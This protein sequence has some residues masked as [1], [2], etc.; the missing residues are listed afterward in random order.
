MDARRRGFGAALLLAVGAL[1]LGRGAAAEL[2]YFQAT[3][4]LDGIGGPAPA[5][6]AT[7]IASVQGGVHLSALDFPAGVLPVSTSVAPT[8]TG[9]P[10]TNLIIGFANG[11]GHFSH[12]S[13]D[14]PLAGAMAVPGNVRIC[15]LFSCAF[16]VDLPL[17]QNGTRGVGL[18]GPPIAVSGSLFSVSLSGGPWT[19]GNAAIATSA[20][21]AHRAGFAHGPLS[22]TSSTAQAGG[23]LQLVTP[24]SVG[25]ASTV[26]VPLFGVLD[27]HFVPE[28]APLVAVASALAAFGLL[29]RARRR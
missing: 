21:V 20:G 17:T 9:L 12:A 6:T 8:G 13:T 18:G 10:V 1:A 22:L 4:S 2:L 7:G 23:E 27:I 25:V 16:F 14:A 24:V 26:Q 15:V 28:P 29:L 3:L 11:P 19:T 5:A